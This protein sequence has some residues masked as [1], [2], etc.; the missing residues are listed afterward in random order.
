[1]EH[2]PEMVFWYHIVFVLGST[3]AQGGFGHEGHQMGPVRAFWFG[4]FLSNLDE[5]WLT[6]S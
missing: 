5:T 3:Y 4:Q 2:C 6:R 1:M